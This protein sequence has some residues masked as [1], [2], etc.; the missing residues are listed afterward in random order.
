MP[1]DRS[2]HIL[3]VEDDDDHAELVTRALEDHGVG[4]AVVRVKDGAAALDYLERREPFTG[5]PRPDLVF[6]DLRLPLVDGLEVL[7]RIK[8]TPHLKG[9]P[10]VVLTTSAADRDVVRAYDSHVNAYVV[11]PVDHDKLDR[12]IKETSAFWLE[13]NRRPTDPT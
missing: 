5:A 11:K 9:L 7:E 3:L 4:D 10:V 2:V 8:T 12:M 1:D 6:L 13:W